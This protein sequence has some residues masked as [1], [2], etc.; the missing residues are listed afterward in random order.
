MKYCLDRQFTKFTYGLNGEFTKQQRNST[1]VQKNKINKNALT[2]H[3]PVYAGAKYAKT[4]LCFLH[5][6][7][8]FNTADKEQDNPL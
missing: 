6:E 3:S 2:T 7:L 1:S 8:L 5:Y 4:A